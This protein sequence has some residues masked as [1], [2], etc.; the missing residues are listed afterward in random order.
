MREWWDNRADIQ[1]EDGNYKAKRF[2]KEEIIDGS[3][4]LD[5]C[6]YPHK[7]EEI[8]DPMELIESYKEKRAELNAQIDAVLK[9][10][11]AI[12]NNPEA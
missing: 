3:Y 11:T 6:G 4:N 2:T 7:V 8:L 5:L 9:E 12:L 1:D 10:I